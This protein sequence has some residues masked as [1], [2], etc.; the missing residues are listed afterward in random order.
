MGTISHSWQL[1]LPLP[2]GECR[3][4]F[5]ILLNEVS[6]HWVSQGAV[7][8]HSPLIYLVRCGLQCLLLGIL[9]GGASSFSESMKFPLSVHPSLSAALA[10]KP[11]IAAHLW[12]VC[13]H[14]STQLPE[15]IS[16]L[17]GERCIGFS[18]QKW[19]NRMLMT[20]RFIKTLNW[21]L[22]QKHWRFWKRI[23]LW[24]LQLQEELSWNEEL[25][26]HYLGHEVQQFC[27]L[28]SQ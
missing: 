5:V 25:I 20:A 12:M 11:Q 1:L 18:E 4:Y 3:S 13:A 8:R 27:A 10:K 28:H 7:W 16:D 19:E 2:Q 26:K 22:L 24:H 23:Y 14:H 6:A 17:I 9:Q 15:C 21:N